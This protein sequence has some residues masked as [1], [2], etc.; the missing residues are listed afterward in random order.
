MHDFDDF[1]PDE[2]DEEV[3]EDMD[4][5]AL[6]AMMDAQEDSLLVAQRLFRSGAVVTDESLRVLERSH[7][8]QLYAS[9][10]VAIDGLLDLG[11]VCQA[12]S[13]A[14]S[15]A[16]GGEMTPAALVRMEDDPFRDRSARDD[17]ILW[18]HRN[19]YPASHPALDV[20]MSLLE[21][22]QVDLAQA[23]CLNGPVEYQLSVFKGNGGRYD[24][25]RDAFPVD[26]PEDTD[27]RRVSVIVYLTDDSQSS[28]GGGLKVFRPIGSEQTIEA[29]AGRVVVF[30]SGVVDNEVLP[31]YNMH[32]SV[33]AWMR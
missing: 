32:A 4:E 18:L 13:I 1:N 11:T 31:V 8:A 9:G 16:E 5:M 22:V 15:L 30:L 27:Q 26:D 24:R 12:R 2:M 25:H 20:V 10:F 23:I 3:A 33:S 17:V 14:L 7:I 6:L 29:V 28:Q 21:G 19:E